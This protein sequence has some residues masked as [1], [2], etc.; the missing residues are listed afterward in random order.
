[1]AT[2][3]SSIGYGATEVPI[4]ALNAHYAFRVVR[5]ESL[6]AADPLALIITLAG[7]RRVRSWAPSGKQL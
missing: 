7:E 4:K 2:H 6:F 5:A 3:H 1:V